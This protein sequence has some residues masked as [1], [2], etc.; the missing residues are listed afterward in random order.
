MSRDRTRAS[1]T[2]SSPE[3]DDFHD[4]LSRFDDAAGG[5]IAK[6]DDRA[7]HRSLDFNPAEDAFGCAHALAH[8]RKI[9]ADLVQ[10]LDRILDGRR[11]YAC[12][13]LFR[14]GDPRLRVAD[15]ASQSADLSHQIGL[16]SLQ[17]EQLGFFD[18]PA[19]KERAFA[20]KLFTDQIDLL[21]DRLLLQA[22]GI[23]SLSADA[24]MESFR[25]AICVSTFFRRASNGK[26][27]RVD[28]LVDIPDI[29]ACGFRCEVGGKV[30]L[31]RRPEF[32]PCSAPP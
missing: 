8:V 24:V 16:A 7:A 2:R 19:G 3:R 27:L 14:P 29:D 1:T 10:L 20:R 18:Q 22:S 21:L 5:V 4:R 32:P 31:P 9:G 26:S 28:D 25:A 13:F 30:D 11:A 6:L 12:N 15:V 17:R 23:Y